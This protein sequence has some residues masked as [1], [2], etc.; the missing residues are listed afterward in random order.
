MPLSTINWHWY[1]WIPMKLLCG[2]ICVLDSF[3]SLV[4]NGAVHDICRA[5]A[6]IG[7]HCWCGS[8]FSFSLW[9]AS[10]AVAQAEILTQNHSFI[11][12]SDRWR[13][14]IYQGYGWY[15]CKYCGRSSSVNITCYAF[16]LLW[17][18]ERI[19]GTPVCKIQ[20]FSI[21]II[22]R[23][24]VC[25]IPSGSFFYNLLRGRLELIALCV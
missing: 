24:R 19:Q 8:K 2:A 25:Q 5:I 16:D 21:S 15:S 18:D 10:V 20:L 7:I 6:Y 3:P 23:W 9:F 1:N 11:H 14:K 4:R 13:K 17:E 22:R 12:S